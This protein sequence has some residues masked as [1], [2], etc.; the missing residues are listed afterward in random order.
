M[1]AI[2]TRLKVDA[3]PSYDVD[4]CHVISLV[5]IMSQDTAASS[6]SDPLPIRR[7]HESLVNRI[8]AGEVFAWSWSPYF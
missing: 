5:L 2:N 7:L 4:A 3:E 1:V 6:V 8:A